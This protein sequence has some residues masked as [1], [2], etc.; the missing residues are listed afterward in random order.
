[1]HCYMKDMI[2]QSYQDKVQEQLIR[3]RS[4][5][6]IITKYQDAASKVNR[7]V[8][9][10]VTS[11]GCI[12]IHAK[13]QVIP[14]DVSL[15]NLAEY[16]DSHVSGSLCTHCRSI[17][18]DEMGNQLFYLASL[19]NTLNLSLYDIILQEEKKMST[20]GKYQLR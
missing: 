2:F 20:L 6:D 15:E 18:E 8:V 7:S 11:C 10:A 17:I 16:M 9:K 4:I 5:L 1:V 14:E 12:E 13:K 19:A 3:N